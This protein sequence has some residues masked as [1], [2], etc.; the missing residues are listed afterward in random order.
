MNIP[1]DRRAD[2]SGR[3][4]LAKQIELHLE[5]LIHQRLLAPGVKLPATREL[6]RSLRVNRTTVASAYEELVSGGWARAHVGQGTFVAARAPMP[7]PDGRAPAPARGLATPRL[8]WTGMLSKGAQ[9]AAAEVRRRQ[10]YQVGLGPGVISF[11]G[12]MPDSA[13][14]PTDAFRRVLNGVLRTEGRDVL[15]YHSAAG[16]RPLRE[17]LAGYLL[18]F[19]VE[20]R[21][22]EVLIVNGSQQGFDLVARTLVDPGD[23]VAMEDPS[24]PRAV[25]VFRALGSQLLPVPMNGSGMDQGYLERVIARQTPKLL[26][27]QP[28]AHNPT[29]LTMD[30]SARQE[31]VDLCARHRVPIVEDGFDGAPY[32]G[33]RAPVP[34]KALDA[35]GGVIYIGTFSK[36]LFPGLRL[37]WI[38]APVELVERLETAKQLTDIHT[39]PLIQAAVC[40]FC[41]RRLLDRHQARLYREYSRRR[42][43]L[44]GA[45]RE[46]MPAGVRWTEPAGGFSLL[47]T[48]PEG[49]DAAGL[50]P[51]AIGQGV[52]FTPGTAFF[53]DGGGEG[54][55]RLSFS[56]I[57]ATLIPEGVRRLGAVIRDGARQ[58]ERPSASR[59]SAVPLV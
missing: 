43:A 41:E 53:I 55:L 15:Q 26:Y 42:E 14:F 18:R 51:H 36:I 38:V 27:C 25:Q 4:P 1:L 8:D 20:A 48:L 2:R 50:L 22:E 47:L 28:T 37:G 31:L 17:Y 49:M 57:P 29:G 44:L 59:D 24:Y 56:A 12:G 34:L 9:L 45:L 13:L 5:R 32:Y 46:A 40:H 52:A 6:A 7:S 54:T 16:Y 10:I 30:R 35:S 11:A 58:P 19:G 21:A 39:S 3:L 33:E 23:M